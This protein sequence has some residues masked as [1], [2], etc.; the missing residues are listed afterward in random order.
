MRDRQLGPVGG[1]GNAVALARQRQ[2]AIDAPKE[3]GER[4]TQEQD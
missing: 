1:E 3:F 2:A 4:W